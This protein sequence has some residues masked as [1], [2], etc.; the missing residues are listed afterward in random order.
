MSR[1]RQEDGEVVV[2]DTPM[3]VARKEEWMEAGHGS[4]LK[5]VRW[6]KA[7]KGSRGF[8]PAEQEWC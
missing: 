8:E 3:N 2:S 4:M 7:R 1:C 6:W 5:S